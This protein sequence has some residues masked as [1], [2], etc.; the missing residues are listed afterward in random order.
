MVCATLEDKVEVF[1]HRMNALDDP[2]HADEFVGLFEFPGSSLI[3]PS[4]KKPL[5]SEQA[6]RSW[7]H[8]VYSQ[9]EVLACHFELHRCLQIDSLVLIEATLHSQYSQVNAPDQLESVTTRVTLVV[10]PLEGG[11]KIRQMHCSVPLDRLASATARVFPDPFS[12]C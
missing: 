6:I 7:H 4:S 3:T 1:L 2:E 8:D 5:D 11:W 9:L 10:H 12:D